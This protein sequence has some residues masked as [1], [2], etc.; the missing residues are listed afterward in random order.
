MELQHAEGS[1][2]L[3]L[4]ADTG[5][6]AAALD[7]VALAA[8]YLGP[9]RRIEA[10]NA[11]ALQLGCDIGTGLEDM[12]FEHEDR[13]RFSQMAKQMTRGLTEDENILLLRYSGHSRFMPVWINR[14][15]DGLLVMLTHCNWPSSLP[16]FLKK[17]YRLTQAE[18]DVVEGLCLGATVTELC[19][20]RNR[21]LPTI[22]SHIKSILA[23][24][25]TRSQA[26]LVRLVC[27]LA[28]MIVNREEAWQRFAN[29]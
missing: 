1:E 24:T 16:I 14:Y 8:C 3:P 27:C 20:L 22:R 15:R 9:T 10:A 7:H 23:K 26:D 25:G 5:H 28:S 19:E 21:R 6:S 4:A 11:A 13:D 29:Q 12:P 17:G 2:T 18:I